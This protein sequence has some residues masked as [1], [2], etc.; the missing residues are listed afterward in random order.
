MHAYDI[1][2]L[3]AA[4]RDDAL[5]FHVSTGYVYAALAAEYRWAAAPFALR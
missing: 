1:S 3:N 2:E 4:L 5:F